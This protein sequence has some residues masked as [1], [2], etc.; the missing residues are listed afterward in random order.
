MGK[1]MPA[2]E[3]F[4]KITLLSSDE[5][6]LKNTAEIRIFGRFQKLIWVL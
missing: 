3:R 1:A 2:R 6:T 5:A 4:F